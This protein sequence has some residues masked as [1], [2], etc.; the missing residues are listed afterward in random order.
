MSKKKSSEYLFQKLHEN[1]INMN[2]MMVEEMELSSTHCVTT[3]SFR[4]EMWFK[5]FRSIIPKKFSLERGVIIIDSDGNVSKEIDIA[6]FD[7]Q[8]TP[9]VFQYNNLKFIPI[10]ALAVAIECKSTSLNSSKIKKWCKSL[11]NLKSNSSGIARM[12]AS[13][14]SSNTNPTQKRTRP[15]L[16][17]ACLLKN[18]TV[19]LE[20]LKQYFDFILSESSDE[21]IFRFKVDLRYE[22]EN[23]RFWGNYLNGKEANTD[24]KLDRTEGQ[25]RKTL[26]EL[27]ITDNPILTLNLQLNQLLMLLNNPMLF[28]HYAYADAFNKYINKK[29]IE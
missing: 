7:E 23:L 2:K 4:E 17:L 21:K 11:N 27:R 19:G 13:Y 14:C 20:E 22:D 9:Y 8:Y 25:L 1:Y 15:I 5:F 16:I 29:Q 18:C 10:E 28:P 24:N 3:G 12:T 6:V 26:R